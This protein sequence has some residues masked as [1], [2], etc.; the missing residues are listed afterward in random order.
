MRKKL[1]FLACLISLA[2]VADA[3]LQDARE[4]KQFVDANREEIYE[5]KSKFSLQRGYAVV[6][7]AKREILKGK[8]SRQDDEKYRSVILS[9][10]SGIGFGGLSKSGKKANAG[11]RRTAYLALYTIG[12]NVDAI[13]VDTRLSSV[14]SATSDQRKHVDACNQLIQLANGIR[15][16]GLDSSRARTSVASKR[17]ADLV[18]GTTISLQKPG[19]SLK[20]GTYNPT[21]FELGGDLDQKYRRLPVILSF[22]ETARELLKGKSLFGV[23]AADAVID[24]RDLQADASYRQHRERI[25]KGPTVDPDLLRAARFDTDI[26]VLTV[27]DISDAEKGVFCTLYSKRSLQLLFQTRAVTH[28]VIL[29]PTAVKEVRGLTLFAHPDKVEEKQNST[30]FTY[31][32]DISGVLTELLRAANTCKDIVVNYNPIT[33]IMAY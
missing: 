23:S 5:I 21:A 6:E 19:S 15:K 8:L 13:T 27:K 32:R 1:F 30:N 7:F 20:Y 17:F 2:T 29:N 22:E 28:T 33:R 26:R 31:S 11:E 14:S 9:A 16:N 3:R 18:N 10:L 25:D 4:M 12:I 24:F